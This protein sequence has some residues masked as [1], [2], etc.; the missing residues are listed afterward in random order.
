M[1][2]DNHPYHQA[3]LTDEFSTNSREQPVV[4]GH[5][6]DLRTLVEHYI[7]AKRTS[8]SPA[9]TASAV[10]FSNAGSRGWLTRTTGSRH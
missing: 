8:G 5:R 3:S 1:D 4:Q 10:R 2:R 7:T 6:S 9:Y